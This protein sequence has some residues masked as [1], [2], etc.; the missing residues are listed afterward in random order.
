M[1]LMVVTLEVSRLSSWLKA[2]AYCRV[3]RGIRQREARG[4]ERRWRGRGR[5][6][7]SSARGVACVCVAQLG[8]AAG[9]KAQAEAHSE[10]VAHVC[11]A[12]GVKAQRLVESIRILRLHGRA[13]CMCML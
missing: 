5:A 11:D 9:Q 6:Q 1:A 12:G 4:T 10:H 2:D 3:Q 13:L 8:S 7:Q